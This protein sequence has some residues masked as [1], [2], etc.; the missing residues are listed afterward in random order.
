MSRID[1]TDVNQKVPIDQVRPYGDHLLVEMIDRRQTDSG[2][3]IPAGERSASRFAK[4]LAVGSGYENPATFEVYP[5]DYKPGDIVILMDYAGMRLYVDGEKYRLIREHGIWAKA[6]MDLSRP[7]KPLLGVHPVTD[8]ILMTFPK[9]E[10]SLS[11]ILELPGNTQTICRVGNIVKSGAG[12]RN[13]RTGF[14][15]PNCVEGGERVVAMRFSGANVWIGKQEFRLCNDID[16]KAIIE[17]DGKVDVV[18]DR[19]SVV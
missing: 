14:V 2:I 19:K 13:L 8:H 1:I 3:I 6:E 16:I 15:H 7:S 10:R 9:E 5:L 18:A 12:K 4:V 17:G 11:G